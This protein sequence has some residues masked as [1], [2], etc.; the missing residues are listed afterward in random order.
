M[1]IH[2]DVGFLC[3]MLAIHEQREALARTSDEARAE[4]RIVRRYE[5]R[6]ER[7]WGKSP[8]MG[9]NPFA[10]PQVHPD[11]KRPTGDHRPQPER[12]T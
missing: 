1:T 4:A 2:E 10:R 5:D 8:R 3:H 6:I 9:H 12:T 7:V 11:G